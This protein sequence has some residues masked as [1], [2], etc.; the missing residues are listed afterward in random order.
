MEYKGFAS[1]LPRQRIVAFASAEENEETL[2][3]LGVNQRMRQL[4]RG[5]F[6][7]ELASRSTESVEL[8]ADRFSTACSMFLEPP[9]GTVGFLFL[10]CATGRVLASGCPVAGD[11]LVVLPPGSGIDLTTPDLT[12][13]EAIAIPVARFDEM[14]E[15]LCTTP[16]RVRHKGLAVIEGNP[17]RLQNL[18][19]SV[20][21]LLNQDRDPGSEQVADLVAETILWLECHSGDSRS[22]GFPVARARRRVAKLAQEFIEEHYRGTV[23]TEDLC[24]VTGVGARVLQRC[25]REYFDMT[26]REYL[27]A[28]RLDAAFRALVAASSANG[29]VAA[30]A[31]DH[32]FNHL[33]RFSVEF[34]RRFGQLPRETL[35]L[36]VSLSHSG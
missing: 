16:E 20:L 35:A 7:A 27:K 34:H 3:R 17:A 15:T 1:D 21:G 26:C 6:R 23:R 4:G 22:D 2:R 24:R 13:S 33:G 11:K 30:V 36:S 32:G 31:G 8:F 29:T 19:K 12:G 9:A 10:R 28:V 18:A 14:S 25:F 5:Q